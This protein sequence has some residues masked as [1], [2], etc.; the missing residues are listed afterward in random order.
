MAKFFALF[1][2]IVSFS[3]LSFIK[4]GEA[5]I[6]SPSNQSQN[7]A[8][9]YEP[10]LV[11]TSDTWLSPESNY[12]LPSELIVKDDTGV[13]W[14]LA[15]GSEEKFVISLCP[16]FRTTDPEVEIILEVLNEVF[17]N[18]K[19]CMFVR[20]FTRNEPHA[21]ER[22]PQISLEKR[23]QDDGSPVTCGVSD[24][25]QLIDALYYNCVSDQRLVEYTV[26]LQATQ[27]DSTKVPPFEPIR[28][29]MYEICYDFQ[30]NQTLWTKYTP[31][32]P[33]LIAD[34]ISLHKTLSDIDIKDFSTDISSL[35][36]SSARFENLKKSYQLTSPSTSSVFT[37]VPEDHM[38]MLYWKK[39]TSHIINSAPLL[40]EF[41]PIMKA[42]NDGIFN[43]SH[44][45]F[46]KSKDILKI[47]TA[48]DTEV[49]PM[50]NFISS[51]DIVK[52]DE[53]QLKLKKDAEIINLFKP[54]IWYKFV[55]NESEKSGVVIVLHNT[56]E[57][58]PFK[59][60][61]DNEIIDCDIKKWSAYSEHI[62]DKSL[63]NVYCCRASENM[64]KEMFSIQVKLENAL[65]D[66]EAMIPV[67]RVTFKDFPKYKGNDSASEA[68][69]TTAINL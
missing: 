51:F 26:E 47:Y 9:K 60:C 41:I 40:H 46:V 68:A 22:E 52:G 14:Q 4:Q 53:I 65:F 49:I 23:K 1:L 55:Y 24:Q 20:E 54:N 8:D 18:S 30:R 31:M 44:N 17:P 64:V 58:I 59:E 2:I 3:A 45:L 69:E 57:N 15:S 50:M 7:L 42:I 32:T 16:E 63:D 19:K 48:A 34:K 62:S 39:A 38:A 43:A 12:E 27:R 33:P 13:K 28:Y 29:F 56:R 37:L 25:Q 10:F 6:T 5:G 21:C 11:V 36:L 61:S 67:K 66:I 35:N